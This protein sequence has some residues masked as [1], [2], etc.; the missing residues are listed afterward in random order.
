MF[1]TFFIE[2]VQHTFAEQAA[3]MIRLYIRQKLSNAAKMAKKE[4]RKE[5]KSC[6]GGN[7]DNAEESDEC[8]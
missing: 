3:S 1:F 7:G 4:G 8:L 2:D 6:I 5:T